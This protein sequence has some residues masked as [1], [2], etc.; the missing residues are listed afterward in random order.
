MRINTTVDGQGAVAAKLR[1]AGD[2]ASNG[3]DIVQRLPQFYHVGEIRK[4][5]CKRALGTW[6]CKANVPHCQ[7]VLWRARALQHR[8]E[9]LVATRAHLVVLC[10]AK[11]WLLTRQGA[12]LAAQ[13]L[14]T[15]STTNE[16]GI[17]AGRGCGCSAVAGGAGP[18]SAVTR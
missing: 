10:S 1:A 14:P 12:A 7:E 16:S 8:A 9:G 3:V 2:L 13:R 4:F 15:T 17:S 6:D 18:K 11:Y 5:V